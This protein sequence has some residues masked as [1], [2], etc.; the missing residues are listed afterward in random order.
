MAVDALAA[1]EKFATTAT[2][3]QIA[4]NIIEDAAALRYYW[5]RR[6]PNADLTV[7]EQD[8]GLTRGNVADPLHPEPDTLIQR[9]RSF[10]ALDTAFEFR[11][12]AVQ[13][14]IEQG[15]GSPALASVLGSARGL[16]AVGRTA[17]FAGDLVDG[18]LLMQM[19][20]V[21]LDV[22]TSLTPGVSWGRDIYEAVTGRI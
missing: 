2:G 9:V 6:T 13:S 14:L 12:N 19:A 3:E 16:A 21:V 7:V 17:F 1:A 4:R 22:A 20:T 15:G 8:G 5:R 18:A 11:A 10:S